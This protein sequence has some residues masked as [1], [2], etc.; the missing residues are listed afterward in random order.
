ME[1]GKGQEMELEE[2]TETRPTC[3]AIEV[4]EP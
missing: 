4:L 1:E 3:R 2:W